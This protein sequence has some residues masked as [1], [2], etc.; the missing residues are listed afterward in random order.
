LIVGML[1]LFFIT[2]GHTCPM[3]PELTK[4]DIPD[5]ISQS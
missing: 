1:W 4:N 3:Q 5:Q 2:T